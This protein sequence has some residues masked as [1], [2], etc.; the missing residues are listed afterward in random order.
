MDASSCSSEGVGTSSPV[1]LG[2][3]DVSS[4]LHLK[5]PDLA[6]EDQELQDLLSPAGK[7]ANIKPA[8]KGFRIGF[9][10][11]ADCR[12]KRAATSKLSP[13][14]RP[15]SGG[16]TQVNLALPEVV[17]CRDVARLFQ[18]MVQR[19]KRLNRCIKGKLIAHDWSNAL[20]FAH[21]EGASPL[22]ASRKNL[23]NSAAPDS[24]HPPREDLNTTF[25][26]H[27]D[28]QSQRARDT[29]SRS[30]RLSIG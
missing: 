15:R 20:L 19:S 28:C 24:C 11:A 3:C 22:R 7:P 17:P 4:V 12:R 2:S 6:R 21:S 13:A 1:H 16:T 5:A 8:R 26:P 23:F 14:I 27:L 30:F 18:H 10:R 25:R 29:R 9:W